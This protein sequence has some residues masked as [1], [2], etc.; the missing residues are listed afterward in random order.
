ML[1]K[2]SVQSL[3]PKYGDLFGANSGKVKSVVG[4]LGT[5]KQF[6]V[7][8]RDYFARLARRHLSYFLSRTRSDQ[9]GPGPAFLGRLIHGDALALDCREATP[10]GRRCSSLAEAARKHGT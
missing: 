8:A 2:A 9:V 10:S 6:A 5:V 1:P 7:L 4:G 3:V